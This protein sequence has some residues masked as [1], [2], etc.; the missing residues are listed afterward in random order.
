MKHIKAVL[1]ILLAALVLPLYSQEEAT[2][3][4]TTDSQEESEAVSSDYGYSEKVLEDWEVEGEEE[5]IE[6]KN[7]T[8]EANG[9]KDLEYKVTIR[10]QK[11][12]P[13][14]VSKKYL[15]VKI[16]GK[17]GDWLSIMPVKDIEID[18]YARSIA[19]WVYGK[20][21]SGDLSIYVQDINKKNHKLSLGKLNFLGWRKLII[22]VPS[23]VVQEDEFLNQRKSIKILKITYEPNNTTRLPRWQYFYL[24]DLTAMVREKYTDEQSDDW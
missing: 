1:F 7:V 21:F 4:A 19:M 20:R 2:G 18:K 13:I 3:P 5:P 12:A 9:Q 17:D 24:D 8:I 10:D 22:K 15:G 16:K 14:Q 11:P 6:A 23:E